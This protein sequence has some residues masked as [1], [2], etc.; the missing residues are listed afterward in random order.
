MKEQPRYGY[1]P[2]W[3]EDGND[4]LHPEDVELAR[5][6]IPSTRVFRREGQQ[7][8]F[9]VLHYGDLRLRVLHTLWQEITSEGFEIGDWV[10]ILSRGRRNTPRTATIR[11]MRWDK[12]GRKLHYQVL[13]NDQ[14]IAR[15][16]T[17]EDLRH[18]EP[19]EAALRK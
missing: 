6:I 9:D 7:G 2:W 16:Y 18:V 10:E 13:E 12:R 1:Y 8:P 5:Q 17:A 14:P 11:E 15:S 4:W 3:P 19:T